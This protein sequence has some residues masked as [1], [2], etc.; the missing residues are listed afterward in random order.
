MYIFLQR[1]GSLLN[2]KN[3]LVKIFEGCITVWILEIVPQKQN[4]LT[5]SIKVF[6]NDSVTQKCCEENSHKGNQEIN[7]EK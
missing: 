7:L 1:S 3:T 2:I 6:K 4:N 5:K